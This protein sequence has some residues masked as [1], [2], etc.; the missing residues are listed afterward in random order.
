MISETDITEVIY[1]VMAK[2]KGLLIGNRV[3]VQVETEGNLLLC[4]GKWMSFI[5]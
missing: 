1:E 2:N 4:D 3:A 5:L